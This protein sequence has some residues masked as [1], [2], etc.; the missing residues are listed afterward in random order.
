MTKKGS[1]RMAYDVHLV[2]IR[3]S[4]LQNFN[5]SRRDFN[6]MVT[7]IRSFHL[8]GLDK[9]WYMQQ[10]A[11]YLRKQQ[12]FPDAGGSPTPLSGAL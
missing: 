12:H 6:Y 1:H 4:F 9:L 5:I 3:R 11:L 2:L 8:L 7:L 10:Y